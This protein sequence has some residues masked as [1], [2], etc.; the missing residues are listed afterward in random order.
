MSNLDLLRELVRVCS[1][2]S[3]PDAR[4]TLAAAGVPLDCGSVWGFDHVETIGAH[5][6]QP[7]PA[8]APAVIV[9]HFDSHKLVDLVAVGL[10][11]RSCR[12]LTGTCTVLGSD[13]LDEARWRDEPARFYADPIAWFASGRDGAVVIDW[14]A[15]RYELADLPGIACNDEGTARRIDEALRQPMPLPPIYVR[16]ACHA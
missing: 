15:A 9:P 3:H 8:G 5:H 6:Y 13:H 16:E 11:S 7:D 12:T 2:A 14:Q 1:A 10:R 4:A